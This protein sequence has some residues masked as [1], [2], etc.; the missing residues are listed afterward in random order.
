M[1]IGSLTER[2]SVHS[3]DIAL[4]YLVTLRTAVHFGTTRLVFFVCGR[5]GK[6]VDRPP[7]LACVNLYF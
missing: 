2:V 7:L 1:T 3:L 4:W 5:H 6:L